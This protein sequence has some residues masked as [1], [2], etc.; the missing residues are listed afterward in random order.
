MASTSAAGTTAT[1]PPP[2]SPAPAQTSPNGSSHK[3]DI[4]SI[5]GPV[6]AAVV[7]LLAFSL[8][9]FRWWRRRREGAQFEPA[10]ERVIAPFP[11]PGHSVEA[12]KNESGS[13]LVG[14]SANESQSAFN[15]IPVMEKHR[16]DIA[17]PTVRSGT[18][19]GTGTDAGLTTLVSVVPTSTA[20]ARSETPQSSP[21]MQIEVGA[22]EFPSQPRLHPVDVD[23]IIEL[24][25]Q[26][27]DPGPRFAGADHLAPPPSYPAS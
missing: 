14:L 17:T 22:Q 16:Q 25:A 20:L 8:F 27:I 18:T 9:A 23:H 3:T 4:G 12:W 10:I 11:P 21:P 7:V 15:A 5:V 19:Q 24:I 13:N 26:R 2:T 1:S 6:I